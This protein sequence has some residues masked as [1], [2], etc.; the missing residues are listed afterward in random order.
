M[1]DAKGISPPKKD[2]CQD[3][4]MV[5]YTKPR[6][7]K[8]AADILNKMGIETYCPLALTERR[9]SDRKKKVWVP[10]IPSYVFV[11]VSFKRKN[12]VF[13]SG[14]VVRYLWHQGKPAEVKES[15]MEAMRSIL[16]Y[17]IEETLVEQ[18]CVG[19]NIEVPNGPFAGHRALVEDIERK[20]IYLI[21]AESGLRVRIKLA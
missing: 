6:S 15:E 2:T 19:E 4:W 17:D 20:Y 5:L 10:L 7:E 8:K 9:W 12:D 3:P 1:K 21:L 11:R 14:Y 16:K 13:E 18:Y